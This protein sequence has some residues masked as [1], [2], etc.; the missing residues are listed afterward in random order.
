MNSGRYFFAT[1]LTCFL[2]HPALADKIQLSNGQSMEGIIKSENKTELVLDIG[3]GS[4]TIRKNTIKSITRADE[5]EQGKL[6]A[7]WSREYFLNKRYTPEGLE[8]LAE[9]F[10][11]ITG[12]RQGLLNAMRSIAAAEAEE[13]KLNEE[14]LALRAKLIAVSKSLASAKPADDHQAYNALVVQNNALTAEISI[15]HDS[16]EKAQKSQSGIHDVTSG[17]ISALTD[18]TGKFNKRREEYLQSRK[19]ELR[20]LFFDEILKRLQPLAAEFREYSLQTEKQGNSSVVNVSINGSLSVRLLLD[21]GASVVTISE[22]IAKKLSLNLAQA[23]QTFVFLADG[24]KVEAKSVTL[25]SIKLGDA[26]VENIQAIVLPSPPSDH[27]DG[28]LGMN[29]LQNFVMNLDS[30]GKLQLKQFK[31]AAK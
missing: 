18:Y 5:N 22:P 21:T 29:F 11:T 24:K 13:K 20:D 31:G 6:L 23:P 15:K 8:D 2:L 30:T 7:K 10:K 16:L 27:V 26:L 9:G 14:L 4:M 12:K 3:I 28:L 25:K 1:L 17:Y 19:D